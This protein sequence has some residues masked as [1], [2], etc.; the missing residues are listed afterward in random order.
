MPSLFDRLKPQRGKREYLRKV[1]GIGRSPRESHA[2]SAQEAVSASASASSSPSRLREPTSEHHPT[3]LTHS[4]LLDNFA[5]PSTAGLLGKQHESFG[6]ADSQA[7]LSDVA[8][9]GDRNHEATLAGSFQ[10]AHNFRIDNPT[11]LNVVNKSKV[12]YKIEKPLNDRVFVEKF[13]KGIDIGGTVL[14]I[15]DKKRVSGAE[16]DS[17]DR[18]PPPRCHPE[19]RKELR[20]TLNAWVSNPRRRWCFIWLSGPAG[21]GKSAVA[22]TF[23]EYCQGIGQLGA[24]FFFSKLQQRDSP[25]GLIA[26]LAYQFALEHAGYNHLITQILSHNPGILDKT[27]RVQ[28]YKLIV[29][30]FAFLATQQSADNSSQ[31]PLVVIIDGLDECSDEDAQ[32]QLIQLI[33]EYVHMPTLGQRPLIWLVCSRPEWHIKREFAQADPRIESGREEISCNAAE[34]VKDVY[35]ILKDGLQKIRNKT[36]WTL[37][38][39]QPQAQWPVESKLQ[40][41]SLRVGGLPVLASTVIRFVGEGSGSPD[42]RLEICLMYLEAVG[43]PGKVKPL[44]SLDS[45]YQQIMIRVPQSILPVAKQILAFYILSRSHMKQLMG[46]VGGG[47]FERVGEVGSFLGIDRD[48]FYSALQNLHSVIDVPPAELALEK[49]IEFFHKSFPDFLQDASRSKVFALDMNRARYDIAVRTLDWHNHFIS[50]NCQ[51]EECALSSYAEHKLGDTRWI[52]YEI[53]DEA[54]PSISR[55]KDFARLNCWHLCNTVLFDSS[56]PIVAE[57]AQFNFCHLPP[58]AS[59]TGNPDLRRLLVCLPTFLEGEANDAG[60]IRYRTL[61]EL[62]KHLADRFTAPLPLSNSLPRD[63]TAEERSFW[64]ISSHLPDEEIPSLNDIPMAFW[65]GQGDRTVLAL[66]TKSARERLRK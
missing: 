51:L 19:T 25:N 64:F 36:S 13:L 31:K 40:R 43:E 3:L 42:S 11:F 30:P 5:E 53:S 33:G 49:P 63:L 8:G 27:L 38:R 15:L 10:G 1:L 45:F 41:L 56:D 2:G 6:S 29:E 48:T 17:S 9:H 52:R 39:N 59:G 24:T 14:L 47:Y 16:V 34:D 35:R 58:F 55:L 18:E 12:V 57:L 4:Q 66:L 65:I 23:A 26:T 22:Q 61:T 50:V 21:A 32:C 60:L 37:S 28:F 62:D 54:E 7:G 44:D 20:E 46:R